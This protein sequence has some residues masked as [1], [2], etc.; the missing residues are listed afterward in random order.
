[1]AD[2]KPVV[3][4]IMG[5][6]SDLGVMEGCTAELEALGV[7]YELVIASAHRT[8]AKVHE[9]ASTAADRGIKV[10]IAAAGR[11][12]GWCRG[13]LYAAAGHRRAYEDE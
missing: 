2:Q 10:I 6:K 7:P 12:P 5:S 11:S 8:P 13:C 3:G 4:I 9:W 1:M